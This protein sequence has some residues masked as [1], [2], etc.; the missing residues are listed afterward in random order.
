MGRRVRRDGGRNLLRRLLRHRAAL[1]LTLWVAFIA[2]P[3]ASVSA[4]PQPARAWEHARALVRDIGPRPSESIE[5]E[6]AELYVEQHFA[7]VGLEPMR[8][9]V[10]TQSLPAIE[11]AGDLIQP[12]RER[13]AD[14]DSVIAL[15]PATVDVPGPAILVMAHIDTVPGSPS[16]IDNAAA[17]G[18]LLELARSLA[19]TGERPHPMI[20]AA[21]AAEEVGLLGARAIAADERL[22]PIGLAISMDLIG[23]SGPITLNGVSPHLGEAGLMRVQRASEQ[24]RVAVEAPLTHQVVSRLAPQV[25]RSDHGAFTERGVPAFHLFHR[26]PGRIY[27]DY[28]RPTDDLEQIDATA[29]ASALALL[30][31]IALDPQPL[32][33][34]ADAKPA[35]W[36]GGGWI[37][38]HRTLVVCEL[39][40]MLVVL[41]G[42]VSSWRGT[43]EQRPRPL[44][45]AM[46]V[47]LGLAAWIGVVAID[48]LLT[49]VSNHPQP[50]IHAPGRNT[51][52]L[53]LALAS[54]LLLAAF[55]LRK[56]PML[57]R[58]SGT[59]ALVI[60]VGPGVALVWLGVPELAWLP[61]TSAAALAATVW[62]DRTRSKAMLVALAAFP[63]WACVD[64]ELLREASFHGFLPARLQLSWIVLVPF[65]AV[66]LAA[67]R[68][69]APL[70]LVLRHRLW[71]AA[72]AILVLFA[73]VLGG[74]LGGRHCE[75][76][77]FTADGL[78]CERIA[79][80]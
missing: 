34:A 8:V 71:I 29:P 79:A 48:G 19:Q 40:L 46:A 10:G 21:T 64:P 60:A 15:L 59:T 11:I 42:L 75:A 38:G 39:L 37:V 69:L 36:F 18:V 50:W 74:P 12:Q 3:T 47:G 30:T 66:S 52:A 20:F 56:H 54:L 24:A 67:L 7:S 27:L 80:R 25:E 16:A 49:A 73:I 6:Q 43:A 28:H 5:V 13:S 41:A 35:T 63:A 57:A 31:A 51:L 45:A 26:G 72:A 76:A 53:M 9:P 62:V 33:L 22:G 44:G 17:V 78:S 65:L 32:P 68:L 70:S 55:P 58:A 77:A 14:D 1:V 61:L 23:R 4:Q 2:T